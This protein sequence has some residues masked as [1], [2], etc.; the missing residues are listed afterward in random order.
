MKRPVIFLTAMLLSVI[1]FA[2][3]IQVYP[4]V[5]EDVITINGCFNYESFDLD[6]DTVVDIND[7][8]EEKQVTISF[9][10]YV[11]QFVYGFKTEQHFEIMCYLGHLKQGIYIMVIEF[12][13]KIYKNKIIKS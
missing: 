6:L 13:N 8:V 2:Q 12:D 1:S 3:D 5:V 11:G 10:N 4:T 7:K 9:F